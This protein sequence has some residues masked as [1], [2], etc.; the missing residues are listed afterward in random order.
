ML[1]TIKKWCYTIGTLGPLGEWATG[2]LIA[3]LLTIPFLYVLA[4]FYYHSIIGTLAFL[5]CLLL[6]LVIIS[7]LAHRHPEMHY[8]ASFI[9]SQAY[10]FLLTFVGINLTLKRILAGYLLFHLLRLFIPL[11]FYKIWQWNI[12]AW[13]YALGIIMQDVTTALSINIFF[14]I[15]LWLAL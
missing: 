5:F 8:G 3:T 9:I 2:H 12:R 6:K 15:V 1:K 11:I 10:A 13:P 14:R 7:Y 4:W